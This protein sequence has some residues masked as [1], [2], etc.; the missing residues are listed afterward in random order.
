MRSPGV[1]DDPEW[2]P[3]M[4]RTVSCC[5]AILCLLGSEASART[6]FSLVLSGA[7]GIPPIVTGASGS[8]ICVLSDAGD[9]L[10]I[11]LSFTGIEGDYAASHIHGPGTALQSA[12]LRFTLQ[13]VVTSDQR[14]RACENVWAI[15]AQQRAWM[16]SGLFY[17]NVYSAFAPNGE[18]RGQMVADP[19]PTRR[20]S[21]ARL[22]A[23]F[24]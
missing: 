13:P 21:F 14:S 8:G 10:V 2:E 12:G 18:L 4:S 16:T 23:L 3:L 11:S 22:K 24:R 15:P 6:G 1:A 5:A 7:A 17:V 19:T 9:T 20:S